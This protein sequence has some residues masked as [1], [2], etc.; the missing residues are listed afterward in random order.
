MGVAEVRGGGE[1]E[2]GAPRRCCAR[3][4]VSHDTLTRA[5]RRQAARGVRAKPSGPRAG[6]ASA[7]R[8]RMHSNTS[9]RA[10]P[11]RSDAAAL[12]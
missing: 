12:L 11:L 3:G 4:L 2:R 1:R 8:Q 5:E 9:G 10:S 7:A 6:S